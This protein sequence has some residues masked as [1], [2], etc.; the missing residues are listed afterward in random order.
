MKRPV[1]EAKNPT[2]KTQTPDQRP[3]SKGFGGI[4]CPR[5]TSPYLPITPEKKKSASML[6]LELDT[7]HTLSSVPKP[8]SSPLKRPAKSGGEDEPRLEE[9]TKTKAGGEEPQQLSTPPQQLLIRKRTTGPSNLHAYTS[10]LLASRNKC[11]YVQKYA[12]VPRHAEHTPPLLL[13]SDVS[14]LMKYVAC[15]VG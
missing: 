9:R 7:S 3:V 6:L 13:S 5:T 10:P 4:S 15:V 8:S 1:L 11:M 12:C 2:P 14:A